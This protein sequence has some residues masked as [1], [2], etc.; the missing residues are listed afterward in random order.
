MQDKNIPGGFGRPG[1]IFDFIEFFVFEFFSKGEIS[2]FSTVL[3]AFRSH[4]APVVVNT[5]W[6]SS[7]LMCLWD[8]LSYGG[9]EAPFGSLMTPISV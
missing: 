9:S 2:R 3:T 8:Y 4:N 5:W 1:R 6:E 7:S